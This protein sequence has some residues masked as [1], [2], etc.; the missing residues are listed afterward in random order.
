M[1]EQIAA[2]NGIEVAYETFGDPGD[3]ALLLIMGLGMQMVAWDTAFCDQLVAGGF[4]V[5]R[6]DNRDAGHS[7]KIE[8][9]PRPNL[10]AAILGL[11]GSVSYSLAD[12]AADAVGLLDHLGI[13]AAHLV[14]ASLG[15]MIAQTIAIQQPARAASLCSIMAGAGR[16]W[17]ELPSPRILPV[18]LQ[19]PPED[20]DGAI[21]YL[22]RIFRAQGGVEDLAPDEDFLRGL[23]AR[24]HDRDHDR[25]GTERQAIAVLAAPNRYRSL[26]GVRAPTLVI[27]GSVDPL[28]PARAG[29]TVARAIPGARFLMIERL[30]HDLPPA[31]WPRIT[32]AV[33]ANARRAGPPPPA[34]AE[35][36]AAE[37]AAEEAP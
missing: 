34:A 25:A 11:T 20:R 27:H 6:F 24:M 19:R 13:D 17:A 29:K 32:A 28:I 26:R 30:G 18:L 4:H 36:A 8:G 31:I 2:V 22:L 1:T 10:P 3:P 12:M 16:R 33:I 35:P 7:S 15:G 23:A 14:G 9:G 21:E 5:V 37:P